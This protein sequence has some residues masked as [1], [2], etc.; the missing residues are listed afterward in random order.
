MRSKLITAAALLTW[1]FAGCGEGEGER[2]G[3]TS[4]ST[5]DYQ[6]MFADVFRQSHLEKWKENGYVVGFYKPV[7]VGSDVPQ[8]VMEAATRMAESSRNSVE[9]GVEWLIREEDPNP[10]PFI[11]KGEGVAVQVEVDS[12]EL[13]SYVVTVFITWIDAGQ[14]GPGPWKG[15]FHQ[16]AYDCNRENDEWVCESQG[17]FVT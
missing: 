6:S 5:P 15:G 12:K 4:I 14:E 3:F 7:M 10:P 17:D 13:G 11:R 16:V 9:H 1:V 8:E 2:N